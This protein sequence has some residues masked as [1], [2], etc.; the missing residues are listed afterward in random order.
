MNLLQKRAVEIPPKY[1]V[2]FV[3]TL[4]ALSGPGSESSCEIKRLKRLGV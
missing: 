1:S 2:E 3:A 4:A